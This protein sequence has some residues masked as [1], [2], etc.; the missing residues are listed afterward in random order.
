M[1]HLD[2]STVA[3]PAA[4]RDNTH[5]QPDANT[6]LS[7]PPPLKNLSESLLELIYNCRGFAKG[8]S[9]TVSPCFFL[10]SENEPK[11]K[12]KKKKTK[13]IRTVSPRFFSENETKNKKP[14]KKKT[15]ENGKI[16]TRRNSQK[17]KK[18]HGSE[19]KINRE[20]RKKTEKI[21]SDTVPATLLRNPE[22]EQPR[23]FSTDH[24]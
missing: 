15:E 20:K 18:K 2:D 1:L 4:Q 11:K 24:Y 19:E 23:H 10:F 22:I 5:W 6:P 16:G 13:K 12:R 9:R 8:V 21:G 14:K 17:G 7:V 3:S